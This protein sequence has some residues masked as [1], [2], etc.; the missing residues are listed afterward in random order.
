MSNEE[1]DAA[2]REIALRFSEK[3]KEYL[4]EDWTEKVQALNDIVLNHNIDENFKRRFIEA[5]ECLLNNRLTGKNFTDA[6]DTVLKF[7]YKVRCNIFHGTKTVIDMLDK[8]QQ[9]RLKV[10][11]AILLTFNDMLFEALEIRFQWEGKH[12]IDLRFA[13]ENRRRREF[14]RNQFFRR[15]IV[16][17]YNIEIPKGPLFYPCAGNDTYFPI[18]LFLDSISE[19]HFVDIAYVPRLPRLEC[20]VTGYNEEHTRTWLSNK[21]I[22]RDIVSEAVAFEPFDDE[23]NHETIIKLQRRGINPIGHK[24]TAGKIYKQVWHLALDNRKVEIYRHLQDGLAT[25]SM[26]DNIAVF[27]LRRDSE[28]EGGSGQR[29]FQKSIFEY[30]LD[31]LLDNGL[32]VTDGSGLDYLI[33]DSAEWRSL[34]ANSNKTIRDTYKEPDDFVYNNRRFKCLGQCGFGYGPVYVWQVTKL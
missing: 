18:T 33:S 25:F 2:K 12:L 29:W 15:T 24:G 9:T 3:L 1:Q 10:Y 22:P 14:P 20:G 11:T 32:I 27:F 16:S 5:V 31:K 6:L 4:E 26:I 8:D 21:I 23:I 30:I 34:W 28:G 13:N 7:V 19:F 17:N